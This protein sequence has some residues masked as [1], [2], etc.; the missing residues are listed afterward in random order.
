MKEVREEMKDIPISH[1]RT[2][3]HTRVRLDRNSLIRSLE[4]Y[5]L[6]AINRESFN[7]IYDRVEIKIWLDGYRSLW[8]GI[9]RDIEIKVKE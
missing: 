8:M 6:N 9:V 5:S 7:N 3:I 2:D 4:F 1:L